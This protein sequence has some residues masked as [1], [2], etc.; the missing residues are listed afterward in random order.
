MTPVP[1][2]GD[3][4]LAS[5]VPSNV[6]NARESLLWM[7]HRVWPPFARGVK[8]LVHDVSWCAPPGVNLFYVY[9]FA[10]FRFHLILA[11]ASL[12]LLDI[13]GCQDAGGG[14][15]GTVPLKDQVQGI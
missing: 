11:T 10:F 9:C 8:L 1:A 13:I 6:A 15:R 14:R 12:R 7:R 5:E 4:Y 2:D 3:L